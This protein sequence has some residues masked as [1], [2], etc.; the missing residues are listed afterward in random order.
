MYREGEVEDFLD[1]VGGGDGAQHSLDA[2]LLLLHVCLFVQ[3][4]DKSDTNKQKD[5]KQRI[6]QPT[7]QNTF[8]PFRLILQVVIFV[9]V[10]HFGCSLTFNIVS[11]VA[12]S[13][14][15]STVKYTCK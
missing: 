8:V 14:C 3:L 15:F 7:W 6:N 2:V 1:E 4:K 5:M 10:S 9:S 12:L 11:N 13:P